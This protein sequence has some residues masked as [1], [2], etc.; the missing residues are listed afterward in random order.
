MIQM[1]FVIF[2]FHCS[3]SFWFDQKE[4]Q[5]LSNQDRL[6]QQLRNQSFHRILRPIRPVKKQPHQN[7]KP[8]EPE[9]TTLILIIFFSQQECKSIQFFFLKQESVSSDDLS[10]PNTTFFFFFVSSDLLLCIHML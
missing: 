5:G 7:Q 8:S 3:E 10:I 9:V 2:L 6:S 4:E 1:L